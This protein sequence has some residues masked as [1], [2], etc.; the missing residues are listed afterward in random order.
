MKHK[1]F[2]KIFQFHHSNCNCIDTAKNSLL[3]NS[4]EIVNMHQIALRLVLNT[5]RQ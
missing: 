3:K 4:I 1:R 5:Q 2:N